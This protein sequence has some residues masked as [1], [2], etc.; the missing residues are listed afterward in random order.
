[1]YCGC[2]I[3][4]QENS[5]FKPHTGGSPKCTVKTLRKS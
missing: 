5:I 1:L 3:V 4:R 2:G